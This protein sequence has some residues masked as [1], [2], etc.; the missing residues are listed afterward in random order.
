MKTYEYSVSNGKS[1]GCGL[2]TVQSVCADIINAISRYFSSGED[3]HRKDSSLMLLRSAFE[4][5]ERPRTEENYNISV[6]TVRQSPS[7]FSKCVRVTDYN[8]SEIGRGTTDW[9]NVD[10]DTKVPFKNGSSFKE[11][12]LPCRPPRRFT[13]FYPDK[14]F[15]RELVEGDFCKDGRIDNN[16]Y[17]K[18]FCD[19]IPDEALSSGLSVRLDFD[20]RG[21]P[22]PGDEVAFGLKKRND[23]SYLFFARSGD[24]TLCRASIITE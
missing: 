6:W 5:D 14:V 3:G 23:E 9:C 20:F 22:S 15:D 18:S 17:I 16:C 21:E 7:T 4:I 12:S 13:D 11:G 24:K 2:A 10:P 8:G 1:D 19:L